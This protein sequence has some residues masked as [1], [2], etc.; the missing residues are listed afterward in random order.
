MWFGNVLLILTIVPVDGGNLY[1][2]LS[3]IEKNTIEQDV[4]YSSIFRLCI[5]PMFLISSY[6]ALRKT[7]NNKTELTD[8]GISNKIDEK[9]YLT[10]NDNA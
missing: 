1:D 4:L 9:E 6:L 8:D 2:Y 3:Q 5:I 7:K 10:L